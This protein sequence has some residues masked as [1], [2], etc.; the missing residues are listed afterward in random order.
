LADINNVS[1]TEL[2]AYVKKDG[3]RLTLN[4]INYVYDQANDRLIDIDKPK[5]KHTKACRRH[6]RSAA[7]VESVVRNDVATKKASAVFD[8]QVSVRIVSHRLHLCDVDGISGKAAIDGCVHCGILRDD[9]RNEIGSYRCDEQVQVK[10][11]EEVYAEIIIERLPK[12]PST[13]E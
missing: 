8:S 4:K 7:N 11:E 5:R 9:T 1:R 6:S 13:K 10:T 2:A 12:P 3:T